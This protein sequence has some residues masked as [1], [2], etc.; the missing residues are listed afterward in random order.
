VNGYQNERLKAANSSGVDVWLNYTDAA[1]EGS[2]VIPRRANVNARPTADAGL[3]QTIQCGG[4]VFLDG[5]A[6]A[7]GDGDPLS[8]SWT[9][10]FETVT[11]PTA[12]VTLPAGVHVITLTVRDGRGGVD[13]DSVSITVADTKPPSL[14]VSLSPSMLTPVNGELVKI[15]A[16]VR[17]RDRCDAGDVLVALHS[18]AISDPFGTASDATT[19]VQ[20]AELGTGDTEFLLRATHGSRGPGRVYSVTYRATDK[21]GNVSDVS[22]KVSVP[23]KVTAA[24]PPAKTVPRHRSRR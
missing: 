4:E 1:R 10:P 12:V 8:Y 3:D 21:A 9:G 16:S 18:I 20:D 23:Q 11:S 7:D 15:A 22:A 14:E 6:S 24:K 17:A 13:T 2:W 19:D 5:R